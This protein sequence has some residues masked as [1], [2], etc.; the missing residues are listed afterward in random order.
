M[1]T[2][3][4]T[5]PPRPL[6]EGYRETWEDRRIVAPTEMGPG[7]VRAASTASLR[8]FVM[9]WDVQHAQA[10]RLIA[11]YREDTLAGELRFDLLHPRTGVGTLSVRFVQPPVLTPWLPEWWLARTTLDAVISAPL[12]TGALAWPAALPIA[13]LMGA[14]EETHADL[15][16]RSDLP[17]GVMQIRR[18]TMAATRQARATW[19]LTGREVEILEA[20]YE[21]DTVGGALP[22][23]W[24]H[25]IDGQVTVAFAGPLEL[26]AVDADLFEAAVPLEI[27]R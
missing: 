17:G 1:P 18:R 5:L 19:V 10:E 24:E 27:L 15:A 14:Y 4:T 23:T 16:V 8:T 9:A 26:R 22:W 3:P 2:W 20:L 6:V 12:S 25:P 13:P 7:K 21:G 11:F